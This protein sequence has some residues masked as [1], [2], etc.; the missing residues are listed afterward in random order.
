VA[1]SEGGSFGIPKGFAVVNLSIPPFILSGW[2]VADEAIA[3]WLRH[4]ERQL[5]KLI[6]ELDDLMKC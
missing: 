6:S 3:K 5:S 2:Y 4:I 1:T